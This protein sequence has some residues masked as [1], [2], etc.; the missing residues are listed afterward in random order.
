MLSGYIGIRI[1]NVEEKCG[2]G[3]IYIGKLK[4]NKIV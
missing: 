2:L 4:L 3:P 1:V